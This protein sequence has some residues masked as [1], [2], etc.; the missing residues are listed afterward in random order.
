ML[1]PKKWSLFALFGLALVTGC[2]KPGD[3]TKTDPMSDVPPSL[4]PE[5]PLP[6]GEFDGCVSSAALSASSI[7]VNFE[8][9]KDAVMMVL[10]RNGKEFFRTQA[11]VQVSVTDD[12]EGLDEGLSE[13][14]SYR[15]SCV[16][17]IGNSFYMGRKSLSQST[18]VGS[19][20]VFA[21]I[22]S[23]GMTTVNAE[24]FVRVG[25]AATSGTP[26][27]HFEV[28]ASQGN[29]VDWTAAPLYTVNKS[30]ALNANLAVS[31]FPSNVPISFGVRACA[32]NEEEDQNLCD[33]NEASRTTTIVITGA[34][35]VDVDGPVDNTY[36]EGDQLD[37]TL[38]FSE[39]VKFTGGNPCLE[40]RLD[41]VS[42]NRCARLV[43]GQTDEALQFNFRY[44]VQ[45]GATG[46]KED[47]DGIE[48]VSPLKL[49]SGGTL[50]TYP[51]LSKVN[52]G[53]LAPSLT[54]VFVDTVAP[55]IVRLVPPTV[56]SYKRD[57]IMEF[58]LEYTEP[59]YIT[60][61]T[62]RLVIDI[63]GVTQYAEYA[64]GDGED[65]LIFTYIVQD[66][67]N[68]PNG[69]GVNN[70]L[71]L[72][73]ATMGDAI[74]HSA[75]LTFSVPSGLANVK[76][77]STQ[78]TVL[79]VIG[80]SANTTFVTGQDIIFTINF[81][82]KVRVVGG[83]PTLSLALDSGSVN[84][85]YVSGDNS[86][87]LVFKHTVVGANND[88]TGLELGSTISIGG[89]VI[90]RDEAN[91]QANYSF[92]DQSYPTVK[93]DNAQPLISLVEGPFS[94]S[95]GTPSPSRVVKNNVLNFFV[96]FSY[97]VTVNGTPQM[98][99]EVGALTRNANYVS[100]GSS[101][102]RIR[103]TYTIQDGDGDNDGVTLPLNLILNG[104]SIIRQSNSAPA[105]LE[106]PALTAPLIAALAGVRVDALGPTGL[107]ELTMPGTH[108]SV[109]CGTPT[110]TLS[111]SAAD[112]GDAA[113]G[114]GTAL[115]YEFAVGNGT[116]SNSARQ[117]YQD[118]TPIP[119]GGT[120]VSLADSTICINSSIA[121]NATVYV[122][123]RAKDSLGN[124]SPDIVSSSYIVDTLPPSPLAIT[125]P[126]SGENVDAPIVIEGTCEYNSAG[127][128]PNM[129]SF[130]WFQADGTTTATDVTGGSATCA[131]GG[132][133]TS[134]G[135][136]A[137]VDAD[138]KLYIEQTDRA[139]NVSRVGTNAPGEP[140]VQLPF[141]VQMPVRTFTSTGTWTV[142]AGVTSISV[143]LWGGGGG[144]GS[145]SAAIGGGGGLTTVTG[146]SVSPGQ[147][148]AI[149]VGGGGEG[150]SPG[151][152]SGGAPG[153]GNSASANCGGGGGYSG[154][155]VSGS[156]TYIGI[157]GGG[158]GAC[159]GAFGGA[160]GG[161]IGGNG[162]WI[163]GSSIAG[164][165]GT[166]LAGGTGN[167]NSGCAGGVGGN[168][169]AYQGGNW[170]GAGG[171]GYFGGGGSCY[172]N[173]TL[174]AGGGGG[175]SFPA[176]AGTRASGAT[177][178]GT[179]DV[180]YVSGT[181]RGGLIP[182]ASGGAGRVVITW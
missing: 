151:G 99:L 7:D 74:G 71:D 154:I 159:Y 158:G 148:L 167:T 4:D 114:V 43:A 73:G 29:T 102:T 95:T 34:S 41:N 44:T 6:L 131:P 19:P 91:N 66:G 105:D 62:P 22:S 67:E 104:G 27:H 61:G 20:P 14:I 123:L 18:M 140:L 3:L 53:L 82:E 121:E 125:S 15:Y 149:E 137:S 127:G 65:T 59:V 49:G 78:P 136:S 97:P 143:K 38:T 164:Q 103:F 47:L 2:I 87:Q 51:A 75:D 169:A 55:E 146:I 42:T 32:Y 80:P 113:A 17:Y 33:D 101:S 94:N 108:H 119:P 161:D 25:W 180:H 115:V 40:I 165:G 28:Y 39:L 166:Q 21:G 157:A 63:G 172:V 139:G 64:S 163:G 117:V 96:T 150:S 69:I 52:L 132:I 124:I 30:S 50:R 111:R 88:L 93:I 56:G 36:Q 168:G 182:N 107:S 92:G 31:S 112:S 11:K 9:P 173:T 54:G 177:P 142:P 155:K 174:A 156:T 60:G 160:G 5:G 23:A 179:T 76:V 162:G 118:W 106:M 152:S 116:G 89:G 45:G 10:L 171:G 70:T 37:F 90:I 129:I 84:P 120:P 100:S 144:A 141:H 86:S 178:P 135:F 134:T 57:Q 145:T 109:R 138:R 48:V 133:F 153:G 46:D 8:W 13:G 81:S 122:S 126:N 175:S 176:G 110:M 77:D 128:S 24:D 130:Y 181:G 85:R 79:A 58:A 147:V 26:V 68:D 16:A 83:V 35:I 98:P 1:A 72:N 170:H 12:G